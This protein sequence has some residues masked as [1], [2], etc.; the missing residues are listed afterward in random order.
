MTSELIQA[1]GVKLYK[2]IHKLIALI[3]N[4]EG[5]PQE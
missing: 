4:K 3:W 1:G 2:E 5:L